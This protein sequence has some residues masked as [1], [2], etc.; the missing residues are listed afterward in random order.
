MAKGLREMALAG[1]AGADDEHRGAFSEI[2]AGGKLV[3]ERAVQL[4]Q[5]LEVELIECFGGA[6]G[7]A[8]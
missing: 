5:P 1:A 4:R 6:E 8:A 3:H 2:A 7:R